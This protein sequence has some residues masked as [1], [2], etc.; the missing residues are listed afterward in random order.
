[1]VYPVVDLFAA[2]DPALVAPAEF[3]PLFR[4]SVPDEACQFLVEPE[5]S[6]RTRPNAA[7][8]RKL[9]FEVLQAPSEE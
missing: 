1:M 6:C 3:P 9:S 2:S 7:I 8:S 4:P 5:A